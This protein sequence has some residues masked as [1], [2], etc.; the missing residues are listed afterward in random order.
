MFLLWWQSSCHSIVFVLCRLTNCSAVPWLSRSVAGLSPQNSG[1]IPGQSKRDLCGH[2]GTGTGFPPSTSVFTCQYHSTIAPY[3]SS[4]SLLR[5]DPMRVMA[6][7]FLR[8]L[9][10]TQR[11]TPVGRTP[12]DEWSARHR[13]LYL[14]T[15]STQQTSIHTSGGI[16]THDLSRRADCSVLTLPEIQTGEA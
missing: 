13:D 1:S 4:S 3:L 16:R 6:S 15:H 5:C 7:S 11:R 14:T 10:H 2:S 9:Y 12:L 8:I